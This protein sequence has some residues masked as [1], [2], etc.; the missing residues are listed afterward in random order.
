[1]STKS[2]DDVKTLFADAESG[3]EISVA[4]SQVMVG[5]LNATNVMGCMGADAD[6]LETDDVTLVSFVLDASISM[7]E[8]EDVVR[9]SYD[10]LVQALNGSKQAGSMLVSTRN[11]ATQEQILHGFKQV[12]EI[13]KIGGQYVANGS[14]TALYDALISAMMGIRSY[15]KQLNDS[16]IRT[17]CVVIVCSDGDDNDSKNSATTVRTLSE[18]FLK[19][20]MFY[21]VYVG[22]GPNLD[23]IADAVGFPNK[24][25]TTKD[26]SGIRKTMG[27]VSKSIIRASQTQITSNNTFFS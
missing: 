24:L 19:S 9:E 25:T 4:A 14:S 8:H 15:A 13:D 10:E 20:E 12:E 26:A 7:E 11:F 18:D 1:M 5:N 22:F 3:G 17:K 27:L 2:V 21:L 16:G 6:D 23:H